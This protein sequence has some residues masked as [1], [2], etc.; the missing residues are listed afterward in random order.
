MLGVSRKAPLPTASAARAELRRFA[1]PAKAAFFPRFFKTGPGEYGEGD[2]FLGLTVP[3]TRGVAKAF[4]ALP[5]DE[6]RK[7]LASQIHEERLLALIILTERYDQAGKAERAK[8][9]RFYMLNRKHVNNWDLVDSSA[10]Q[11]VGAQ[12]EAGDH[13]LLDRLAKSKVLWDRR[14]AMVATYHGIRQRRFEH[15]LRVALLLLRDE[16]DLIHKAVGWML[17]EVGKRDEEVLVNFLAETYQNM[18]RTM[19][20]YAIERFPEVTR[21]R[22]LKGKV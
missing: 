7:L 10:H 14:I 12:L 5:L 16:H 13:S 3:Q 18:P 20:R 4:V 19:L 1:N 9:F 2:K 8:I 22:Y 6:I 17:R 11:I 15:A 21:Q